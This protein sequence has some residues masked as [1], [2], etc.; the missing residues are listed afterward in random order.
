M[1]HVILAD[2]HQVV[3]DG[4]KAI[5]VQEDDIKVAGEALDGEKLLALLR[6]SDGQPIVV[7][8]DINMPGID[9][10]EATKII[11]Q[12]HPHVRILIL[13]MYNKPTFIK[14]LIEA[15]VSG[16][17]LKNTGREELLRAIR[18][19]AGGEEYFGS[20][21]TKTIMNS[22]KSGADPTVELTKREIEILKLVAKAY[23]TAEI[24][25]KLFI[26]TYTVDTHRKNLLS[27]LNLKNTAGLVNYAVQ[28]GLTDDK[29]Q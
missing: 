29:F 1:I 26:S 9:G 10:I 7:L 25:E 15:G 2:D 14:G 11:R 21:V 18:T 16:Y 24:A 22:F 28:N 19:V 27:K 23:S 5:L 3:I 8:L 13:S 12:K 4:L 20:E 6:K 17:I